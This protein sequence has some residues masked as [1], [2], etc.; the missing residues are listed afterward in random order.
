VSSE[1]S[2]IDQKTRGRNE[3]NNKFEIKIEKYA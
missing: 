1:L 3:M 2:T